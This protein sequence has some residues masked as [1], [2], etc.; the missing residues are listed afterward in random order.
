M[1]PHHPH[2]VKQLKGH[3]SIPGTHILNGLLSEPK[4][5]SKEAV[6]LSLRG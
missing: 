2:L 1:G 6:E 3:V 5:F 4:L